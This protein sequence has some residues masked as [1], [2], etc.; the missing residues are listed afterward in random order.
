MIRR[1]DLWIGA[2]ADG[3]FGMESLL[4]ADLLY[5]LSDWLGLS[6]WRVPGSIGRWMGSLIR[7]LRG[8]SAVSMGNLPAGA[9]RRARVYRRETTTTREPT[10]SK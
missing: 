1:T 4:V 5:E 6:V 7:Q 8:E 3:W 2:W 10:A 9:Y